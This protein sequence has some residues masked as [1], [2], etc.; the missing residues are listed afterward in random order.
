[1]SLTRRTP[2]T[3]KVQHVSSESDVSNLELDNVLS[4]GRRHKRLRGADQDP[5]EEK[6]LRE[7]LLSLLTD[8]KKE[9]DKTLNKLCTEISELKIQNSKIQS[10]YG[11]MEKALQFLSTQ[12]EDIK[13]KFLE[14]QRE[15]KESLNYINILENKLNDLDRKAKLAIV[16]FRNLPLTKSNIRPVS[17][18]ELCN[19]IFT[20]CDKFNVDV[21]PSDIK[22]IYK[23]ENK[24][25]NFT[26]VT[27]FTSVLKKNKILNGA[28][29]FNRTNFKNKL[30]SETI[31]L[32]GPASPI[33]VNE[34]L[35]NK[36]RKLF[37]MARDKCNT[38]KYKYC[39]TN[40][41]RIFMR[42]R[43]GDKRV[44]IKNEADLEALKQD[45]I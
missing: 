33:F 20:I 43:D 24:S 44:E 28:K 40:K 39:W 4:A 18:E 2:P 17:Q 15:R 14:M 3:V 41:G 10:A 23:I 22:D 30:S 8:W 1:M 31:G 34:S 25:G 37:S 19:F 13:N 7:D 38:L 32:S 9:Q 29:E 27:E 26:V 11:D 6:D 12:Y 16:E 42:R 35:T 36:D 5:T 21:Q 45:N